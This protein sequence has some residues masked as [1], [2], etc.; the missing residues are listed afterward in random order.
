MFKLSILKVIVFEKN[1][2]LKYI[3]GDVG[4]VQN[5]FLPTGNRAFDSFV[6]PSQIVY[7]LEILELRHLIFWKHKL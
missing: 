4:Y 6:H 1:K 7:F 5:F 2:S 3:L